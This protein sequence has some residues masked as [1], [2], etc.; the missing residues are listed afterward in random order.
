MSCSHLP[1]PEAAIRHL[2][3]IV[4]GRGADTGFG[5]HGACRMSPGDRWLDAGARVGRGYGATGFAR[6]Y[7]ADRVLAIYTA[8]SEISVMADRGSSPAIWYHRFGR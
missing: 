7:L 1:E 4:D 2:A 6:H 3:N 5:I 8:R